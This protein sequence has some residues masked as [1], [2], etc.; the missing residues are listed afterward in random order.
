MMKIGSAIL[1]TKS[2]EEIPVSNVTISYDDPKC[3]MCDKVCKSKAGLSKHMN[4]IHLEL[5]PSQLQ[6]HN[7]Y[8]A[9][10]YTSGDM[11]L[12]VAFIPIHIIDMERKGNLVR[13]YLGKNGKQWGD[14][15][16]DAPYEHNAGRVY[17]E[18]VTGTLDVS[19]NFDHQ[20]F[21]PC[22]GTVNSRWT[23]QDMID[24]KVP[25]LVVLPKLDDFW[26]YSFDDAL[27]HPEAKKYYFGD[28]VNEVQNG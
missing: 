1:K 13:F 4:A 5:S 12:D 14:D 28:I 22:D 24:R 11:T 26:C 19:F 16:D 2:G 21:E 27:G 18:F 20:L 25:C 17:D 10:H 9:K 3:P 6:Q 15:W 7:D 8:M 23:K